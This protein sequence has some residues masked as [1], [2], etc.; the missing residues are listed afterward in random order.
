MKVR[1][2]LLLGAAA[3]V[4]AGSFFLPNAVARVTDLRRL[5]N[6]VMIDSQ[7]ISFAVAPDLTLPE[8][9]ALAGNA[10]TETLPLSTGNSMDH[11]TARAR[12]AHEIRRFFQGGAFEFEFHGLSVSEGLAALIIDT[13]VPARYMIVWEFDI[14]DNSGNLATAVIDDETGVIVRLIYRMGDRYGPLISVGEAASLDD[15]FYSAARRLSEMLAEYYGV[16]VVLADY[17]FSGRLSYYRA[18]LSDGGSTVPMY[19]VV[20]PASFTVNERV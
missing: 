8:R 20:R 3:L 14:V 19:G 7:R 17:Q 1:H 4:L 9:I 16:S 10:S 18:D 15:L 2:Y 13:F 6:L 11:E 5:D 12:V